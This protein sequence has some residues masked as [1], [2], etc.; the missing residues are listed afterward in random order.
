MFAM[1]DDVAVFWST[2]P[3]DKRFAV[4]ETVWRDGRALA[5]EDLVFL[6]DDRD[7]FWPTE[8]DERFAV[9]DTVSRDGRTL[10]RGELFFW[11]DD[12]DVFGSTK[13]HNDGFALQENVSR[14][15]GALAGCENE[16]N[17]VEGKLWHSVTLGH[18]GH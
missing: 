9:P 11:N 5:C 15:G 12:R 10:A 1:E 3:R 2:K 6:W 4:P 13:R 14:D 8:G 16:R 7:F 18:G 17:V